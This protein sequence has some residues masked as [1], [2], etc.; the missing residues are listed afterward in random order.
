MRFLTREWHSGLHSDEVAEQVEDDYRRHIT[1]V[2]PQLPPPLRDLARG[3]DL[4][5]GLI[6]L[7]EVD[8]A[9][10]ELRLALRCGDLQVG[11]FDLDLCYRGVRIDLLDRAVL[12]IIARDPTTEVLYSEVDVFDDDVFVHRV[13]FSPFYREIHVVFT[14]LSMTRT[15][16]SDR[17]AE[18]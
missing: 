5:D 9:A 8:V 2:L 4:H 12:D 13:L 11:Y 15:P 17:Y 16:R 10:R 14:G 18:A 7:V 3:V 1:A 6:R